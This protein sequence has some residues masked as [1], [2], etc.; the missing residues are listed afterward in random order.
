MKRSRS[1]FIIGI[2]IMVLGAIFAAFALAPL[3]PGGV[4]TG[5]LEFGGKGLGA[6][7]SLEL[8]LG[9]IIIIVGFSLQKFGYRHKVIF[10]AVAVIAVFFLSAFAT[11]SSLNSYLY[12]T[13]IDVTIQY[14]TNDQGYFGSSSQTFPITNQPNQ[15]LTVDEISSFNISIL[16]REFSSANSNDG[17]ASIKATIPAA[18]GFSGSQ[19]TSVQITS[20]SPSLPI[21]FS[22]GSLI[23]IKLNLI[24]PGYST[25]QNCVPQYCSHG[26]YY[27]P[28]DLVITTTNG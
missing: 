1:T 5:P 28:I 4:P 12:F 19:T 25:G 18:A 27:G 26:E 13:G 7:N 15:N 2:A 14:G 22:P 6:V 17:I 10:S 21:S 3:L 9:A 8:L 23:V 20:V 11:L 24:A 16:L